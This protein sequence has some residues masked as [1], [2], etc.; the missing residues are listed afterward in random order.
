MTLQELAN[1]L[2]EIFNID[3]L[4]VDNGKCIVKEEG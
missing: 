1:K 2:R 3:Y 4:A